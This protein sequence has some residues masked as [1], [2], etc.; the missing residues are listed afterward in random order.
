MKR[1]TLLLLLNIFLGISLFAQQ[2]PFVYGAENTGV[3][4]AKPVLPSL[5][6]LPVIAPLTDPFAWSDGSGRSVDF[7]DWER[8]RNE[9][10]A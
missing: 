4:F 6:E 8:R 1:K 2:V 5:N 3:G 7:K 9:I 10:G